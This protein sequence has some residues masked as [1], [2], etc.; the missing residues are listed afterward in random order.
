MTVSITLTFIPSIQQRTKEI[1]EAQI[2]RGNAMKKLKDWLPLLLPLL[3]S[4][5]ENAVN[6]SESMTSRGFE[7]QP[8]GK[9]TKVILINLIFAAFLIFSA[10]ALSLFDYP[11]FLTITLYTLGGC[12]FVGSFVSASRKIKVTRYRKEIW[13]IK[14]I[15]SSGILVTVLFSLFIL[16]QVEILPSFSYSPYPNLNVPGFSM[17]GSLIIITPLLPLLMRKND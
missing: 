17:I 14:D 2:I 16:F 6:L 10:W 12:L 4:S 11:R 7:T 9:N 3:I 5:L 8:D 1:K 15:I 13:F